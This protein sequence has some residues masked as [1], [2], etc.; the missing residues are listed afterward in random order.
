MNPFVLFGL[1]A[2]TIPLLLHLLNL[3]KLRTVDFSSL[4]FLKELQRTSMRRVRIRQLLLLALR[5]LLIVALV[6]AFSRPALRGSIAGLGAADAASTMV[7][8]IDDSPSMA[9]RDERG[10]AFARAQQTAVRI[11]SLARDGDRLYVIPLSEARPDATPSAP[12]TPSSVQS[13]VEQMTISASST[14]FRTALRTAAGILAASSDANKEIMLVTDGQAAQITRGGQPGDSIVAIDPQ[15]RVFLLSSPP[16]RLENA[17]I[18]SVSV[19]SRIVVPGKPVRVTARIGNFGDTPL[20]NVVASIYL[21]GTRVAQRAVDLPAHTS[22]EQE[23]RCTPTR[24][25]IQ[26]G[27]A[28]IEDDLLEED[29]R[30]YFTLQVPDEIRVLASGSAAGAT[31]LPALALTLGSDTSLAGTFVVRQTNEAGLAAADLDRFDVLMLCGHRGPSTA[32]ARRIARFV[33]GGGGLVV[34]PGTGSIPLLY[35]EG[36][37]KELGIPHWGSGPVTQPQGTFLTFGN[38]DFSHPL[39]EGMFETPRRGRRKEPSVESPRIL[40]TMAMSTG[41]RGVTVISLSNGAPFLSEYVLERGRIMMFAVEAGL[42]WSDF[43]SKGLF[44]PL[45]HRSV[46]YLAGGASTATPVTAGE[47]LQFTARLRGFSE[48]ETYSLV[49]PDGVTSRIV[50]AFQPVTGLALFDVPAAVEPGVYTVVPDRQE[51]GEVRRPVSAGVANVAPEESDLRTVSDDELARFWNI[52]GV[53]P[54]AV[55]RIAPD[56]SAAEHIRQSRFGV[57]LW[58]HFLVLAVLFALAEMAVGRAP[59]SSAVNEGEV[60]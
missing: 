22:I 39:F 9:V 24:R 50:P 51:A 20:H 37:L 6:L 59:R 3:R 2:A 4:R 52:A 36:L 56:A 32:D 27:Y 15:V 46:M 11:A 10:S 30:R 13:V 35:N 21:E 18:T 29:N 60:R 55:R 40:T 58:R 5:T 44:A 7:I 38:V 45:L 12:R 17:G 49:Q 14:P 19:T 54:S 31:A 33:R 25:G 41:S 28:E 42:D 1:A 16:A 48:R 43:P 34:F 23:F 53:T 57:E 47:P 26:G 8:L